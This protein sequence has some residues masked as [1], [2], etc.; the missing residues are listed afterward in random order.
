MYKPDLMFMNMPGNSSLELD[1]P[2]D[3]AKVTF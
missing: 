2:L 3:T 1:E